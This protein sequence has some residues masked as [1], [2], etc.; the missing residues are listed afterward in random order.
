MKTRSISFCGVLALML[1]VMPACKSK[2]EA[3][4]KSDVVA[5][6]GKRPAAKGQPAGAGDQSARLAEIKA[7][8]CDTACKGQNVCYKKFGLPAADKPETM[9]MCMDGCAALTSE[10]GSADVKLTVG[11]QMLEYAAGRCP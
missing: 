7:I 9:K 8:N 3:A 6:A 4:G 2:D 1:A 11:A 5:A 10:V